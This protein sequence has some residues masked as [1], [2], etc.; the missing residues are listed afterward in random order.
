MELFRIENLSFA[1][2]SNRANRIFTNRVNLT[3]RWNLWN[4]YNRAKDSTR[5][6]VDS[7]LDSTDSTRDFIDSTLDSTYSMQNHAQNLVLENINLNYDSSE[8]LAITGANGGG[9]STLIKLILGI[10]HPANP[11]TITRFIATKDMGYV[12]QSTQA[13]PNF[14]IRAIECVLMGLVGEKIFGFYSKSDR[15]RAIEMLEKV[16]VSHFWDKKIADLSGGQRQRV[17]IARALM[18]RCKLLILDEPS[19]SVDRTSSAQIFAL[20]ESLHRSGVGII[21]ISHDLDLVGKY[22]SSIICL[23]RTII[24]MGAGLCAPNA[25]DSLSQNSTISLESSA[26]KSYVLKSQKPTISLESEMLKSRKIKSQNPRNA[27]QS[28]PQNNPPKDTNA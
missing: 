27:T 11:R 2:D 24:S 6:C 4:R 13:N 17:F 10:L 16:G 5:G 14:P 20:L 9:K 15:F 21:A 22:A 28:H 1:Y 25:C 19:A 12:P 23:N 7:N 3:T 8:F 26:P 18:S